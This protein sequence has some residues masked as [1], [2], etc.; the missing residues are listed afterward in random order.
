MSS[1]ELSRANANLVRVGVL[2]AAAAIVGLPS[3]ARA[4]SCAFGVDFLAPRNGASDV[5][6]NTRL[7]FGEFREDRPPREHVLRD[8]AGNVLNGSWSVLS[9][10]LTRLHVFTPLQELAPR[11]RYEVVLRDGIVASFVTGER[12]DDV[13]PAVPRIREVT[14]HVDSA[15]ER[16]SCDPAQL[17]RV[18]FEADDDAQLAVLD[19]GRTARLD[20]AVPTGEVTELDVP[21]AAG[22]PREFSVGRGPC[23]VNWP[24]A[25]RGRSTTIRVG[26]FDLA[27]N[28]SGFGPEEEIGFSV[29]G[30]SSAPGA[31]TW[32]GLLALAVLRRRR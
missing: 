12:R 20:P 31:L 32:A 19:R 22:A 7:W 4:C 30:C 23:R 27:G 16:S 28:F 2:L 13:A 6:L 8:A 3:V 10:S 26:A 18:S 21:S 25:A 17:L 24:E 5:P 14:E 9:A 15:F 11:T 1:S 29:C